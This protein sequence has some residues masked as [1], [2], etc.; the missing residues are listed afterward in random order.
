[1]GRWWSW[2]TTSTATT[3]STTRWSRTRPRRTPAPPIGRIPERGSGGGM[4]MRA[5]TRAAGVAV[6]VTATWLAGASPGL[7]GDAAGA[8]PVVTGGAVSPEPIVTGDAARAEST[9]AG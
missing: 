9:V 2:A 3:R 6:I 4:T 5:S 1:M 8:E 7:A